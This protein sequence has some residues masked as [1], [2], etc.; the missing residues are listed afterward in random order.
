MAEEVPFLA[1]Q[2]PW[3]RANLIVCS[4]PEIPFDPITEIVVAPPLARLLT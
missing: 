3:E 4:T 2:R 1:G